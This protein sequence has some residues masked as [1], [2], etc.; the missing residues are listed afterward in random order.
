[1]TKQAL[2]Q[3]IRQLKQQ[4]NAIEESPAVISSLLT[5]PRFTRA[6][7]LLLYSALPDEVS[8]GEILDSLTNEGKTVLLPRV[9]NDT[10][11]ELR[12]YTGPADLLKGAY[13]ILEPTGQLF[14]D[15]QQIDVAVVPGMAFDNEGHRLGRGKGYYDRFLKKIPHTYKIGVCFRWQLVDTVPSDPHDILMDCVVSQNGHR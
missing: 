6:R 7:T 1:M 15:Y 10:E 4:H 9:V 11:M 8:T 5:E 3:F 14:T 12:L 2:R 13:G